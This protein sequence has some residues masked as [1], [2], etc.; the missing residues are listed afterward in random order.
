MGAY[1]LAIASAAFYGAADF[2]GGL[3]SRRA[4]I[5]AVVVFSGLAGLGVLA[6]LIPLLSPQS[7]SLPDLAW[8]AAAGLAGGIG[9]G[10]LYR[11]LAIGTMSVIAPTTAV[12]G[13]SIPVVAGI[14]LGE[15][16][17]P[18]TAA[19]M[20]LALVAIVLVS[21]EKRSA[22]QGSSRGIV[23]ALLSGV[24]IGIFYLVLA[25][26]SPDAGL[27]PLLSSRVTS[28]TL[29]TIAALA[30]RHTWRMT[31]QVGWLVVVCGVLDMIANAMYLIA[32]RGGPLS[33]VVT[34]TSLY[35]ASTVILARVVLRER[36]SAWQ[37]TGVACALVAV[38]L[39]VG[40]R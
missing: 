30:G 19:G 13:V 25:E 24:A 29:F 6:V 28:I 2:I 34:L 37:I 27:W 21:Q 5:S 3:T 9:L 16:P 1:F 39:I 31:P 20:A 7:P 8:G 4:N 18:L 23:L 35:P 17:S 11:A 15:R 40:A 12:C 22:G 38:I 26:T 36:L 33:V 10:L 14:L 32:S